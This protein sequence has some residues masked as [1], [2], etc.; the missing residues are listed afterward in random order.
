[1]R[2]FLGLAAV[3]LIAAAVTLAVPATSNAQVIVAPAPIVT[4][5]PVVVYPGYGPYY[6]SYYGPVVRPGVR[7]VR[8]HYRYGYYHARRWHR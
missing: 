4:T 2:K 6:R 5:A 3:G 7:V 8:P 1:M